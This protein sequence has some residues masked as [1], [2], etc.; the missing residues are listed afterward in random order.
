M[1]PVNMA[2][3]RL[4]REFRRDFG[5][6]TQQ[7]LG[8]RIGYKQG[9]VSRIETGKLSAPLH[10]VVK[11]ADEFEMDLGELEELKSFLPEER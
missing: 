8:E 2:F 7:E 9:D 5:E 3:G 1:N 10:L 11:I 4:L 6:L